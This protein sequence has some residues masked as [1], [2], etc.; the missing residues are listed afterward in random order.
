MTFMKKILPLYKRILATGLCITLG[1][2]VGNYTSLAGEYTDELVLKYNGATYNYNNRLVTVEIDGKEL[3][4]G[5]MPAVLINSR[6]MVPVR[7]V[8]E[9]ASINATVN[10]NG[11]TRQV[12]IAYED[13]FIVLTIDSN[14]AYVNNVPVELSAPATLV[15]DMSKQ[16][17][18]TMIP[19]RFVSE[20]LGFDVSWDSDTYT[21]GIHTGKTMEKDEDQEAINNEDDTKEDP[22]VV[23]GEQLDKLEGSKANR[24]LPTA[25]LN[26]PVEFTASGNIS[27]EIEASYS[28][29]DIEAKSYPIA[30]VDDIDYFDANGEIG[31][32]IH[33]DGPISDVD[34]HVWNG[35]FIIEVL[36]GALDLDDTT[37]DYTNNPLVT[38]IRM[39]EHDT[40]D[41]VPYAK[42]V[43][44]LK[45]S[46]YK[47]NL[48]LDDDR[49]TL[50]VTAVNNSIYKVALKQNTN[51]DYID[52][53]GVNATVVEAFRLS[54]PTRIVFDMPNTKTLLGYQA[55][56]A[57]GQYVTAIRT[58]Q[59]EPTVT[60]I[61]IETDGQPDYQVIDLSD[62][63]TRIQI[64][65]PGY[66][67]IVY[68]N[69][70]DNPT[71]IIDPEDNDTISIDHI[72]YEDNYLDREY[73]ITIPGDQREH[74]GSG[75]VN[76]NDNIIDNINVKLD[77]SG[78]TK[79]TIKAK[80][81]HEFRIEETSQ[82][83]VIKAYK[84][85]ELHEKVIVVDA[86][87]GG[88][89]PGAVVGQNFEKY[90]TLGVTL[91][92][93]KLLDQDPDMKVYYTRLEDTRPSL[94][95][96]TDLA[97]EV[98]ADFF[99]S[100]HINSFTSK[101]NGVETLYLPGP[102]TPGLNSFE[103]AAIFQEVFSAN[104]EIADYLSKQRDNLHVLNATDM[105]AIILE[106]GYLTNDHDRQYLTDP[107][108][109]D[110]LAAAIK[111]SIDET[112]KQHPTG[113]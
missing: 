100:I 13:K 106:M 64:L 80:T 44:D 16:Y 3:Q 110:D 86:G 83:L 5:D 61:V 4:T 50:T 12:F 105:P 48:D 63:V 76:I 101:F 42:I 57:Q 87:H 65:E 102:N 94:Y 35:K 72:T 27:E 17:P 85:H 26:A 7:E 71:I 47:F 88:D 39:G 111:L 108:Y 32:K 112:F 43:F 22:T 113:R 15:Q 20:N 75:V 33:T 36:E 58:A 28:E 73:I 89:D 91:E 107:N 40:D 66:E 30:F 69:T 49:D 11:N 103:M 23:S 29:I 6:T 10:W 46:G 99:L 2:G 59:F 79:L 34:T 1:F 31:F 92:L 68:D 60:R 109:Y 81:I 62:G 24:D 98:E 9:S 77:A 21:A 53:T 51:G 84:P 37:I 52:I 95:E 93:K 38:A 96:R 97:N 19:L 104:V 56:V 78:N 54:N 55:S 74:F 67:N 14:T 8:F 82:G 41:G 70:E 25:L 18:K 90:T 45:T